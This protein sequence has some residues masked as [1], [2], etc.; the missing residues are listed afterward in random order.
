MSAAAIVPIPRSPISIRQGTM[1][2]LAF[3][4]SLQKKHGNMVGWMPTKQLEGKIGAGNVLV[5][6]GAGSRAA[7]GDPASRVGEADNACDEES[8]LRVDRDAGVAP[9]EERVG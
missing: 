2:D 1:E 6:V 5:A 4:D 9:T 3:I 8:T 7:G